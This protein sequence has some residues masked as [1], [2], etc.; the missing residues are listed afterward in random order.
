MDQDAA[1]PLLDAEGLQQRLLLGD[2]QLDVAGDE[3]GEPAGVGHG[4]EDLVEDLLGQPPALAQLHGPLAGLAVEG[5]EGRV[6]LVDRAAS[7]SI[8]TTS[9]V[10]KPSVGVIV[11]GLG[12][13]LALEQELDAAQPALD[14]ADPGDD[15]HRVELLRRRLLRVVALGDGE[16]QAV[17]LDGRLD[18]AQRPRPA[19]GDRHGQPGEDHRP[20]HRQDG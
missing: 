18:R 10:R 13:V 19:D 14:L 8:G 5:G 12:A 15:A 16:D 20:P 2:R 4:V 7:R 1:E 6:V 11:E 17:P 3:V 9:A